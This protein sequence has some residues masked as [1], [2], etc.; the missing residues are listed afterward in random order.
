LLFD[1]AVINLLVEGEVDEAVARRI[2]N[3]CGYESGSCYGKKGFPYIK[4][5]IQAFNKSAVV[6]CY[7]TLVDFM[8]TEFKC[9]PE[10][11]EKWLPHRNNLMIFRVVVREIESWIMADR[12]N[13]AKFLQVNIEQIPLKPENEYDPKQKLINIARKSRSKA[14]RDS[15]VPKQNSTAQV[16]RLYNF[17]MKRFIRDYWSLE[18]ARA[19]SSSLDKCIKRI[20]EISF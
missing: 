12:E 10:V 2:I 1:M 6:L 5:K 7:L 13:L 18:N 11:V 14:I 19:N 3:E 16:G 4:E 20:S 8:D 15:L 9:P 17:E